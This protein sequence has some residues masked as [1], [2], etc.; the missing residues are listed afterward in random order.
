MSHDVY[1][2]VN[3]IVKKRKPP[4]PKPTPLV[5]KLIDRDKDLSKLPT[6]T[7]GIENEEKKGFKKFY[8]KEACKHEKVKLEKR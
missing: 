7:W 1:T 8:A 5:A 6:I 4:F 3:N 2:K